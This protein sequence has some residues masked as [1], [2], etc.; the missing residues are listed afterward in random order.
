MTKFQKIQLALSVVVGWSTIFIAIVT[1]IQVS[2]KHH[3]TSFVWVKFGAIL[4]GSIAVSFLVT[5]GLMT[6]LHPILN[7]IAAGTILSVANL[8]MVKMQRE[9]QNNN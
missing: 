5:E 4:A 8:S 7:Y 6:G 1:M 3:G 2:K 9:V